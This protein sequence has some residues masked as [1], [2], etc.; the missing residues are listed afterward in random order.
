MWKWG[1][2]RTAALIGPLVVMDLTFLAANALKFLSG[3]WAAGG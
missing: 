1:P 3:G 2:L